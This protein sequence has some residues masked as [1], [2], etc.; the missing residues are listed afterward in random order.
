M[1]MAARQ[2]PGERLR[3]AREA[4]GLGQAELA[5]IA[6]VHVKTVSK[7]ENDKQPPHANQ[8]G[9]IA[10][11]LGV[12][13]AYLRE[14]TGLAILGP[15]TGFEQMNPEGAGTED[16]ELLHALQLTESLIKK[17]IQRLYGR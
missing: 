10:P 15:L 7:W 9:K 1:S 16:A 2:T 12:S 14:G 5:K 3:E 13:V 11:T 4:A 6:G 8:L 17:R